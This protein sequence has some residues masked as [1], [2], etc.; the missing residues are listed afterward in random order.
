[1]ATRTSVGTGFLITVSF[2]SMEDRSSSHKYTKVL[3]D[4][5]KF[6][7]Q[8]V[9]VN[10]HFTMC[11]HK[12]LLLS[13]VQIILS[14]DRLPHVIDINITNI[15]RSIACLLTN[16]LLCLSLLCFISVNLLTALCLLFKKTGLNYQS[17]NMLIH[18]QRCT[19]I[20]PNGY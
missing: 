17:S 1:M 8:S 12:W 6:S 3:C 5:R 20:F 19:C 7:S 10:V 15:K 2:F 16:S 9:G 14:G 4:I 13:F 11:S 18:Y